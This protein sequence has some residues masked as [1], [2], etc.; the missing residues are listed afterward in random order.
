MDVFVVWISV[1][2]EAIAT[3]S[4]SDNVVFGSTKVSVV[5]LYLVDDTSLYIVVIDLTGESLL[6]PEKIRGI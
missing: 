4:L 3:V 5:V 1:E 6:P 2:F